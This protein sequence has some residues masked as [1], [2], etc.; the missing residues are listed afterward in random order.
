MLA[1]AD[2]D[3]ANASAKTRPSATNYP[4][5]T[6]SRANVSESKRASLIAAKQEG[7]EQNRKSRK[8]LVHF[9]CDAALEPFPFGKVRR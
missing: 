3:P 2:T 7:K 1:N 4:K 9:C 6:G 5:M 8:S